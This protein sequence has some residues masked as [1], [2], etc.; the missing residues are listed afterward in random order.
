[1]TRFLWN[2]HLSINITVYL[3]LIPKAYS[4]KVT[5]G[6]D[7]DFF[8]KFLCWLQKFVIDSS[9]RIFKSIKNKPKFS[10]NS[11]K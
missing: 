9:A 2:V 8:E 4:C 7:P 5:L 1:M 3:I 6:N 11:P 10:R